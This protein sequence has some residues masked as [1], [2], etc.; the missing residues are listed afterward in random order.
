MKESRQLEFKSDVTNTFL[1]TVSAYA[2]YDGGQV[3]FGLDDDGNVVGLQDPVQACLDI[4]NRIND[5]IHPQP[6]YE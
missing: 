1:K 3:I 5:T 2:N 4:E 6:L